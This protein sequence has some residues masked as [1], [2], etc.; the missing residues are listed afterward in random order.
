MRMLKIAIHTY[1]VDMFIVNSVNKITNLDPVFQYVSPYIQKLKKTVKR[2]PGCYF[3]LYRNTVI[4]RVLYF[5]LPH[6]KVIRYAKPVA[7]P[8]QIFA[9]R[10]VVITETIW[11]WSPTTTTVRSFVIIYHM[12]R[13]LKEGH[14]HTQ[15][16]HGDIMNLLWSF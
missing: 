1:R 15:T 14:T 16:Q 2:Q 6:V 10:H 8:S 11:G 5:T 7:L 3:T 4:T 13:K 12:D 9:Q